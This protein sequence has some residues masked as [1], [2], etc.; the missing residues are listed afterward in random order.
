MTSRLKVLM[1]NFS[2]SGKD[3]SAILHVDSSLV[4]K[5]RSGSRTLRPNSS[6]TSQIIRHVMALDRSNQFAKIRLMLSSEYLNIFKCSESEIAIFLKDWL[7]SSGEVTV[8]ARDYFDEVKT[9]KN[10]SRITAY[11]LSGVSGRQ[12]ALLFFLK[13]AQH[14]SPGAELWLYSTE[15]ARQVNSSS[16]FVEERNMRL[17]NLLSDEN[18]IRIIH[19][20]SGFY[21]GLASTLLTWMPMHM[22]G[23]TIAY[24]IPRYKDEQLAYTYYLIK[25]HLALFNWAPIEPQQE[26]NTYLAHEPGLVKKFELVLESHFAESTVLFE[27]YD[28]GMREAGINDL[29][30]VMEQNTNEFHWCTSMPIHCITEER[31]RSI[32][33]ENGISGDELEQDMENLALLKELGR[34]SQHCFFVDLDGIRDSLSLENVVFNELSFICGRDISVSADLFRQVLLE[35]NELNA[36]SDNVKFCIASTD[37]LKKLGRVDI[38]AKENTRVGFSSIKEEPCVLATTEITAVTAIYRYLEE[39]WN[40]TPYICR[41]KEYVVKRIQ[42]TMDGFESREQ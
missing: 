14:V 29:V 19:T 17:M 32:L 15:S 12:Q 8:E 1:E 35:A 16:S 9:L 38:V 42:K 11:S 33:Q 5:W 26:L 13:Y 28:Y 40:S 24:F 21:E 22:T 37:L 4:S 18:S 41:N 27:R 30:S 6:Y 39:L 7:T 36:E 20:F 10:T 25:G 34:R 3:L 2:I 23:R 31:L